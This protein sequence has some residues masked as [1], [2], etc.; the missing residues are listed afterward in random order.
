MGAYPASSLRPNLL[1]LMGASMTERFIS[2]TPF[3]AAEFRSAFGPNYQYQP[4]FLGQ[5]AK[6]GLRL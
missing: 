2:Q 4:S 1:V 6:M 5:T 3:R